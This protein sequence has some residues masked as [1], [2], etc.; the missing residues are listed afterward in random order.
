M[1]VVN[2]KKKHSFSF[3]ILLKILPSLTQRD[4]SV[5][6]FA[7][8]LF[9][10]YKYMLM[11]KILPTIYVDRKPSIDKWTLISFSFLFSL[12]R[13]KLFID[14]FLHFVPTLFFY[15][16]NSHSNRH[17]YNDGCFFFFLFSLFFVVVSY[18]IMLNIQDELSEQFKQIS[19]FNYH[20]F[21]KVL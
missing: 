20:L 9:I 3:D 17:S 5:F 7:I 14:S 18:L 12:L 4:L 2:W 16:I 1:R 15:I 8:T 19:I 6:L 11:R 10:S 13:R 21:V